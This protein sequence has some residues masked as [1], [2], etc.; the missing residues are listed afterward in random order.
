M[1][2][3]EPSQIR[4]MKWLKGIS[5]FIVMIIVGIIFRMKYD[6]FDEMEELLMNNLNKMVAEKVY[7]SLSL[8]IRSMIN[9][10]NGPED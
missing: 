5:F 7:I 2:K 8:N 1:N 10:A 9:I 4:T 6:E 3:L